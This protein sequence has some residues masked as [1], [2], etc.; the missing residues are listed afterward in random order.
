MN[1][2]IAMDSLKG[3]LSSIE[4]NKVMAQGL[5]QVESNWTIQ[6][7]P[8]ADGGEGTV[9]A[10]VNATDGEFIEA[11]VTGPLGKPVRST[12]GILGNK[13]TAVIEVAEACGLPLL[14]KEQLNPLNTTTYG[15]GELIKDALE[16]GCSEFIIGLGGSATNDAGVG[17]LQALGYQ[18]FNHDGALIGF[19]GAE[20]KS[21]AKVDARNVSDKVKAAN[22]QVACDVNNPLYGPNGAAFI[23]GPQKGATP[24]MV[25]ELDN[26]LRHFA[27]VTLKQSGIDLQQISGAGAAGGLGA[28][29]AGFLN[30]KLESG[31]ELVLEQTQ[32]EKKLKGVDFVITGEGK[33]DGQT[34]MGKAPAGIARE[35]A[36]HSIPVIALA[37]DISEGS[38]SLYESGITAYFTIVSG[39]ITLE[40][41]MNPEVT[42]KNLRRTAEQIGRLWCAAK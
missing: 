7:V 36:K 6:T 4:A 28:A 31:V 12:Y 33:L 5:L 19:G 42:L 14:T 17:M 1:I 30:G 13:V 20:L 24:D 39:P 37:G 35:A 40:E 11:V 34:S 23:Y 22:F 2:L 38:P 8:V 26:G 29:F 25:E 9:E 10:L 16:K 21:I 32:L 41:A 15:V 18:F 27:G 3:S